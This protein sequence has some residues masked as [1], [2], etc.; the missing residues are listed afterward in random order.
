MALLVILITTV[1]EDVIFQQ[2]KKWS[3]GEINTYSDRLLS[4]GLVPSAFFQC[5]A[6]HSYEVGSPVVLGKQGRVPLSDLPKSTGR[7][8]KTESHVLCSVLFY[9]F[10]KTDKMQMRESGISGQF[11]V[12]S[13]PLLSG[14]DVQKVFTV[15]M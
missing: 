7:S 15:R 12:I 14:T 6:Q 4:T 10:L 1:Q 13:K 8:A 2:T 11:C 9:N 5:F 3:L